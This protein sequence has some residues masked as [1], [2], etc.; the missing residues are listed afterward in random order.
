MSRK[1]INFPPGVAKNQWQHM[2][3]HLLFSF[4]RFGLSDLQDAC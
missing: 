4:F 1:V 3:M 2:Y